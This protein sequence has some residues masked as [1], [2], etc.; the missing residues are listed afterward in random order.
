MKRE[1]RP[2]HTPPDRETAFLDVY[3]RL[4]GGPFLDGE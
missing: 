4:H 1:C 3:R 2:K